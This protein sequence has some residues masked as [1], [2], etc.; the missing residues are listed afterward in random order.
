MKLY[1]TP[2][3]FILTATFFVFCDQHKTKPNKVDEVTIID[4]NKQPEQTKREEIIAYAKKYMGTKYCYAGGDPKTG[5][6]CSG[7]VNFVYKN[8]DVDLPRSSSGFATIGRTLKPEEFRIGD[9]LVFY[10]YKDNK[11][12]GHVGIICEANGMKSKFIH[13]SSG[14]EMAVIISELGS[15][16]YT[17][18]FYKGINVLGE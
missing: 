12:V 17:K 10:G 15:D 4:T 2:V 11:S 6:D 9:I 1:K 13:S 7:F 5:F 18:R 3:F 16:Q 14:K 8:F